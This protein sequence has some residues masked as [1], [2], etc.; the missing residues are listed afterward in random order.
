MVHKHY[1]SY[2]YIY[3]IPIQGKKKWQKQKVYLYFLIYGYGYAA[4][5]S[6][7]NSNLK[8]FFTPN[9]SINGKLKKYKY[10]KPP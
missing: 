9:D 2:P 3:N 8:I 1:N 4:F 7:I 6:F 10:F 5:H